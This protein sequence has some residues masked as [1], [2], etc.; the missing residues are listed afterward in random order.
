[1][2]PRTAAR[3]VGWLKRFAVA[4]MSVLGHMVRATLGMPPPPLP[5]S[6]AEREVL[7]ASIAATAERH[8]RAAHCHVCL[9]HV[10]TC[11]SGAPGGDGYGDDYGDSYGGAPGG[12]GDSYGGGASGCSGSTKSAQC[13]I[14]GARCSSRSV[15]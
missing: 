6:A 3:L 10:H 2:T 5:L 9:V 14:I 12:Y 15:R 11:N 1:M 8:R 4:V 13:C 7:R